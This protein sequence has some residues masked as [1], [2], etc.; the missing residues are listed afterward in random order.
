[1]PGLETIYPGIQAGFTLPLQNV[2]GSGVLTFGN[3][4]YVNSTGGSDTANNGKSITNPFATINGAVGAATANNGD[5]IFVLPGHAETITTTTN[6]ALS[7]AGVTIKGIGVGATRPT[8]TF[9][10]ANTANIPLTAKNVTVQNILFV[11]NFLSI[12]SV[13]TVTGTANAADFTVS[14]CEFRDTSSSLGFLTIVTTN[15]TTNTSDRLTFVRNRVNSLSASYGPAITMLCTNDGVVINDNFIVHGGTAADV[16]NIMSAAALVCTNLEVARNICYC[17]ST[18]AS[19]LLI[20]T[21][22]TTDTGLVHDNYVKHFTTSAAV[23][24]TAGSK[25]GEFNNL[26]TGDADASGFVLPAIGAN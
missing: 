21:S 18:T 13:F 2:Q 12:A 5:V 9:T 8:L 23:M 11:G 19:N 22:A 14:D 26:G 20:S 10:T 6:L 17:K 15:S 24:I 25:L 4:W 7:K 16:A 1:M 3:I